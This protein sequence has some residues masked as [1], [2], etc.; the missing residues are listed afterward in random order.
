MNRPYYPQR[1]DPHRPPAR[2]LPAVRPPYAC[3]ESA[4]RSFSMSPMWLNNEGEIRI[5]SP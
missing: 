2:C 4:A 1:N 5:R 3:Y